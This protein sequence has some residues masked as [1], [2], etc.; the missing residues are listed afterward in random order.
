MEAIL[1]LQIL[2]RLQGLRGIP[3]LFSTGLLECMI[4]D[5]YK[6]EVK[7]HGCVME[8]YCRVLTPSIATPALISQYASILVRVHRESRLVNND[9]SPDNL[10]V[11]EN[12]DGVMQPFVS[13]WGLAADEGTNIGSRGIQHNFTI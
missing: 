9:I 3:T 12:S 1:E 8:Q 7:W 6:N 13:D 4:T 5:R 11:L 10:L 2:T